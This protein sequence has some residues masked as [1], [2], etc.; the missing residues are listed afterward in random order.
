MIVR[1]G[2][3]MQRH[4]LRLWFFML[5]VFCLP[6]AE[7]DEQ[8][9]EQT[10]DLY[11]VDAHSQFDTDVDGDL[12]IKRMDEGGVYK[13]ILASRRNRNPGEAADLAEE[14]PDRIVASIR[15]KGGAYAKNKKKYYKKLEKRVNGGR[16]SGIAE[17][18]AFHA[19]KGNKA[20]EVRVAL[21]DDRIQK[22]LGHAKDKGWPLVIHIEFASLEG[23]D[24]EGYMEGLHALLKDN[25]DHPILLIHMGQLPAKDVGALI[26]VYPNIYFLTSHADPVS[27]ADSSQPWINMMD[28]DHFTPEWKQLITQ[29]PE[30]FVFALDNV[31]GDQ[32][33]DTY[34]K[35]IQVWRSALAELPENIANAVAHGN[36]E[37]LWKLEPR[38]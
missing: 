25:P 24:R 29:H 11:F 14:Y 31:W 19:Q 16:F 22:T 26:Q 17:L 5:F 18:L 20:D 8:I 23:S 30:R 6:F 15:T 13:T 1:G 34:M 27:S 38:H 28:K 32:W 35:H 33:R 12:I 21:D 2:I 10:G 4:T 36:A 9:G 37:R 7:A 3:H